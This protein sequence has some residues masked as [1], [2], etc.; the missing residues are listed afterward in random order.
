MKVL[1]V[2]DARTNRSRMKDILDRQKAITI[3]GIWEAV[4]SIMATMLIDSFNFDLYILDGHLGQKLPDGT[5]D[6][7]TAIQLAER[8]FNVKPNACV[9]CWSQSSQVREE[10][11][12]RFYQNDA[13]LALAAAWTKSVGIEKVQ[14]YLVD[15]FPKKFQMQTDEPHLPCSQFI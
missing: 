8:I 14:S 10:F 7:G 9:V 11:I 6:A 1:L 13:K 4:N 2:D 12:Q 3:D 15:L 5:N